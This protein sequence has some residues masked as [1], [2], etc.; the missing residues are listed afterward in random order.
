MWIDCHNC[1]ISASVK[2]PYT[3]DEPFPFFCFRPR[4][5]SASPAPVTGHA[6][7]QPFSPSCG[8]G[9]K[10][11]S[12]TQHTRLS[13]CIYLAHS[14]LCIYPAHLFLS[15]FP[16][17]SSLCIYPAY[18]SLCINISCCSVQYTPL[19]PTPPLPAPPLEHPSAP[20]GLDVI[21]DG[22]PGI[23]IG[24]IVGTVVGCVLG[25]LIVIAASYYLLR[26]YGTCCSVARILVHS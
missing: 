5:L 25:F 1:F 6:P 13:L 9:A 11:L 19:P 24:A 23:S 8:P 14:S 3:H 20:P 12:G 17:H 16:A 7:W 10:I 22:S 21:I 15:I 18:S 2:S 26:R 4:P